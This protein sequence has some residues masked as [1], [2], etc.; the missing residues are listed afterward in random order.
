[1]GLAIV[2]VVEHSCEKV[3]QR[4]RASTGGGLHRTLR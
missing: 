3:D 2:L 4:K 1:M